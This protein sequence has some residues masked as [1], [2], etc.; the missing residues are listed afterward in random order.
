MTVGLCV[1]RGVV[2][3][4]AFE[5]IGKVSASASHDTAFKMRLLGLRQRHPYDRFGMG[6]DDLQVGSRIPP[7]ATDV[8]NIRQ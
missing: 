8:E 7:V 5:G 1:A 6:L 4:E 3:S 2:V